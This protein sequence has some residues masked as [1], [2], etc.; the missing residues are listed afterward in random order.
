MI[1]EKNREVLENIKMWIENNEGLTYVLKVFCEYYQFN[2]GKKFARLL[3]H[4]L[5]LGDSL[6]TI[7]LRELS[8]QMWEERI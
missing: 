7:Q 2:E 5:E 8:E 3:L 1:D 6:L 4:N